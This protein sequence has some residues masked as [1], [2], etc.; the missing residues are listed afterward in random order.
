MAY[1]VECLCLCLLFV[2]CVFF[3]GV[4][5]SARMFACLPGCAGS[6]MFCVCLLYF[7]FVVYTLCFLFLFY[8]LCQTGEVRIWVLPGRASSRVGATAQALVDS[9]HNT[10][11]VCCTGCDRKL[12]SCSSW[13][14]QVLGGRHSDCHSDTFSQK[15]WRDR[16]VVSIRCKS[17]S[18]TG[19]STSSV[20]LL[21]E[22][23]WL[24]GTLIAGSRAMWKMRTV[25]VAS[26]CDNQQ[27]TLLLCIGNSC[28]LQSLKLN[29]GAAVDQWSV[30]DLSRSIG[31]TFIAIRR[32]VTLVLIDIWVTLLGWHKQKCQR[33]LKS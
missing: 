28:D 21:S 16:L 9:Q 32:A 13:P 24:S 26:W 6:Q 25:G 3:G 2:F 7:V 27:Q 12:E 19:S 23:Q 18:K 5:D 17:F 14:G 30:F 11:A 29:S 20:D 15:T 4:L 22:A 1:W 8:V 31:L 33:N 10:T